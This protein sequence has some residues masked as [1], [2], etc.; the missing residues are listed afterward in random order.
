MQTLK[1]MMKVEIIFIKISMSQDQ[2]KTFRIPSAPA[3]AKYGLEL[4]Q[5][6]LYIL[7]SNLLRWAVMS[8]THVFESILQHRNEPS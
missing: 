7:S 6:T 5:A 3:L 2:V 4:W 1:K 8:C